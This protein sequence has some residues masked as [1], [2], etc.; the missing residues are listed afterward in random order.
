[1]QDEF[2]KMHKMMQQMMGGMGRG[3]QQRRSTSTLPRKSLNPTL[4]QDNS[5]Y[6]I[7]LTIPGLDQSELKASID[8][9]I[10]TLFG[11]QKDKFST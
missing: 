7:K 10:L 6:I 8:N 9:N 5:N 2:D 4:T 1:M 3:M 11:V